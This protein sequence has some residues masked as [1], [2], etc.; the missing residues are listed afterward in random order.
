VVDLLVKVL[1][2]NIALAGL[3]QSG[4]TL[5]PHNTARGNLLE[6]VLDRMRQITT[7]HARPLMSE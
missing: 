1:D 2:K 5:G 3:A 6:R 4:I 7:H